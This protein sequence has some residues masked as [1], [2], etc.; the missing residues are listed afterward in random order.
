MKSTPR[1]TL[2]LIVNNVNKMQ[3]APGH[4]VDK[5]SKVERYLARQARRAHYLG[6]RSLETYYNVGYLALRLWRMECAETES[7]AK[8]HRQ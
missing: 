6:V 5:L 1:P 4:A 8:E 2:M 7:F 3:H